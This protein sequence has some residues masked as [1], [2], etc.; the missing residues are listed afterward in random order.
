MLSVALNCGGSGGGVGTDASDGA[1]E[2]GGVGVRAR[3]SGRR[4]NREVTRSKRS[5]NASNSD[6]GLWVNAD[7]STSL[8]A[9]KQEKYSYIIDN[10]IWW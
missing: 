6:A 4:S 7:G 5:S 3:N 2:R 10:I 9:D 1:G 8:P